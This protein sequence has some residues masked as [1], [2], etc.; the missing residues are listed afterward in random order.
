MMKRERA[1]GVLMQNY[2]HGV[3]GK[4]PLDM[5]HDS[6]CI[7]RQMHTTKGCECHGYEHECGQGR[8]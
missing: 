3:R 8:T 7:L 2:G 1:D 4:S 5:R 6:V